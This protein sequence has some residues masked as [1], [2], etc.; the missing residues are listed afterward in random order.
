MKKFNKVFNII[1]LL[2]LIIIFVFGAL[3]TIQAF[4]AKDKQFST[5][6]SGLATAS[7]LLFIYMQVRAQQNEHESNLKVYAT[8][9]KTNLS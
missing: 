1:L 4:L 5:W 6:Y 2:F 9:K 3:F 8:H 7:S